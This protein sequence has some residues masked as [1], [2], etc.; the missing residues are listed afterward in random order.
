MTPVNPHLIIDIENGGF[1]SKRNPL[2][3][4]GWTWTDHGFDVFDTGVVKILPPEGTIIRSSKD[5]II[6][7]GAWIIE[8][9]AADVNGY[10]RQV[11]EDQGAVGYREGIRRFMDG[12]GR[13]PINRV[14]AHNKSTEERWL[15]IHAPAFA[16][17]VKEWECT[18][19]ALREYYKSKG[20]TKPTG[21]VVNPD[22]SVTPG[23]LTLAGSC[24]LTGH[25]HSGLHGA[26]EDCYATAALAKWLKLFQPKRH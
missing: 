13:F 19:A 11:W 10:D 25:V 7:E 16:S 15:G 9:Q 18:M 17:Q 26:L 22:G 24:R 21:T 5:Q 8:K 20:V 4:L 6:P 2:L 14:F 12:M 3:E 1:D 23:Q